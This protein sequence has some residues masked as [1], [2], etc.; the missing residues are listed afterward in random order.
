MRRRLVGDCFVYLFC[1]DILDYVVEIVFRS[2]RVEALCSS[3]NALRRKYGPA[4]A[5]KIELR[6]LQIEA[7][8][9][10]EAMRSPR[11]VPWN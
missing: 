2:Y 6:L 8:E 4:G 9:T 10:L 1:N 11:E 5:R 7:A 3:E